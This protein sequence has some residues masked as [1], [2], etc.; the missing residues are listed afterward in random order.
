M[1]RA[2]AFHP[3]DPDLL[4]FAIACRVFVADAESAKV[5]FQLGGHVTDVTK[6]AFDK[7]GR[8][9]ATADESGLVRIYDVPDYDRN[10]SEQKPRLIEDG[11]ILGSHDG[12]VFDLRF[13]PD[14]SNVASAGRDQTI[15]IWRVAPLVATGSQTDLTEL[16]ETKLPK[17]VKKLE[18][19]DL[20]LIGDAGSCPDALQH[21]QQSQH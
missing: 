7:D 2:M 8:R 3:K 19:L 10:A 4:A 15:R 12:T 21:A 18:K 9:I 13:S 6:V 11:V 1:V 20:C 17:G 5:L 16:V 14:G